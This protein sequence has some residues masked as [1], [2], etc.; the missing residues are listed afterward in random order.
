MEQG[1][2]L[3]DPQRHGSNTYRYGHDPHVVCLAV[4]SLALWMLGFP[5]QAVQRSREAVALGS[6]LGQPTTLA[7][8]LHFASMVQQQRG[9]RTSLQANTATNLTLAQEHGFSFWRAGSL[10]LQGWALTDH[11]T[12]Q[13]GIEQMQQGIAEWQATGGETHK[14]YYLGLLADALARK[15]EVE[16]ALRVVADALDQVHR[17]GECFHEAELHRLRGQ[18]LLQRTPD[19]A[20]D[21][22]TSFHR[23]LAVARQQQAKSLELRAAMNLVRLCRQQGRQAKATPIL[24]DCY[25]WFTEGFATTDLQA[26]KALLDD[27]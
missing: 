11:G 23:A 24:A 22:E 19:A 13:T 4:G 7:L 20:L 1:I 15:G 12:H 5:E 27:A 2:A 6:E 10:V 18:L 8:A 9:D 16:E 17:S 26:A 21:A 3:Y 14:T 25:N